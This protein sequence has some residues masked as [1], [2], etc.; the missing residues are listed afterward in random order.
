MVAKRLCLDFPE[1]CFQALRTYLCILG[2]KREINSVNLSGI[3]SSF[4]IK[5]FGM[6]TQA[7]SNNKT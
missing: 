4:N 3:N 1:R 7:H 6:R 5:T 2:S